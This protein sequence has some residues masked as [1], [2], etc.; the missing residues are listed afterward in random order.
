VHV[1]RALLGE[2]ASNIAKVIEQRRSHG[3]DAALTPAPAA[4][5]TRIFGR[6]LAEGARNLIGG[7]DKEGA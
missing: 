1:A 4:S 3:A 2:F 5:G 6:A 7:K